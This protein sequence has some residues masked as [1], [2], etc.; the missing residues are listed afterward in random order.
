VLA[1][2]AGPHRDIVVLNAAAGLVV[3]G[4]AAALEDGLRLA[5]DTIDS[6]AAAA[7]LERM[8]MASQQAAAADA[9]GR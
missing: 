9:A 1:G 3:A 8:V 6:G 5:A 2:D 4:R 7:A